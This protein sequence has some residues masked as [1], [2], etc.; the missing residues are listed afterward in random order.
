VIRLLKLVAV[1]VL[2]W[3]C[4]RVY[5][6]AHSVH[7]ADGVLVEDFPSQHNY[8]D[9]KPPTHHGA[10]TLIPRAHYDI[11]G[12]V[13]ARERYRDDFLSALSPRSIIGVTKALARR[14]RYTVLVE[15][16]HWMDAL[17]PLSRQSGDDAPAPATHRRQAIRS[18]WS[19]CTD[20]QVRVRPHANC[21]ASDA[22][23]AGGLGCLTR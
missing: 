6:P 10:Y 15:P 2:G 3:G 20:A 18:L 7:P 16:S 4:W 12:R 14:A 11:T 8:V 17:T 13:L 21:T 22:R 19:V 1:A 9:G 5:G 23:W